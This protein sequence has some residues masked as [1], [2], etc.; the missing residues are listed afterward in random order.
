MDS[1]LRQFRTLIG[2]PA[3]LNVEQAAVL[4]GFQPHDLPVLVAAGLLK[5]L[6]K[7]S[8]NSVKYFATAELEEL[9]RDIRWLS[10]ATDTVQAR[11]RRK[12]QA[13]LSRSKMDTPSDIN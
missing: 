12:N 9:R 4:L 1:D 13:I 10:R 7:P 6:G 8:A 11:W 2:L 5:P 3:R